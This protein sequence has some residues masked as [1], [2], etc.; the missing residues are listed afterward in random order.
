MNIIENYNKAL[1]EIYEHVGFTEDW[2]ICPIDDATEYFWTVDK[3]EVRY[4]DSVEELESGE[5]NSYSD[6]I[7]TQR[8]YSKWVYEGEKYTMIFCDPHVDGMKYFRIFDN[9][10][11]IK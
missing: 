10:K 6:E 7:Y 2:V 9:S 8:F 11:N 1:K 4:A 5:G 3:D